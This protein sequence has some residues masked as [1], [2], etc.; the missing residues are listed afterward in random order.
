MLNALI[1]KCFHSPLGGELGQLSTGPMTGL[2]EKPPS[3]LTLVY[4]NQLRP[5]IIELQA[6][7]PQA[8]HKGEASSHDSRIFN[9]QGQWI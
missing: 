7:D 4:K 2:A 3:R 8:P 5:S 1:R 9:H 6:R